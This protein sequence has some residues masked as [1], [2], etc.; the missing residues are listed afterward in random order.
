MQA[1]MRHVFCQSKLLSKAESS[2]SQVLGPG[3]HETLL[4]HHITPR[5]VAG[6]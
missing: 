5:A 1:A 3:M 2:S 6:P 4:K